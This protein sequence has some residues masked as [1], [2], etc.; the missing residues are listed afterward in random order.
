MEIQNGNRKLKHLILEFNEGN[1]QLPPFQRPYVWKIRKTLNLLDSLYRE[2]P[3]G[4]I[5]L[6]G[7]S[8]GSKLRPKR[9]PSVGDKHVPFTSFVIDGQQRLTSLIAAFGLSEISDQSNGRSLQC[10]IELTTD[11]SDGDGIR[12]T[13]LFHSPANKRDGD[14][15]SDDT[16]TRVWLR[17]LVDDG[18]ID[19]LRQSKK[20]ELEQ[21]HDKKQI[22]EATGRIT[23][24]H[25]IGGFA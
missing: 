10:S 18:A 5:Y 7:P 25:E 21:T 15:P 17:N 1:I 9:H 11:D 12:L 6:W 20:T 22:G 23:K 4:A 2:Y 8:A 19:G 16:P 14:G 24:A 3:I 13:R